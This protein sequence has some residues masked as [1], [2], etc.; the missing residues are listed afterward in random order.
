AYSSSKGALSILT[1]CLAEELKGYSVK[2]N[3]LALGAVQTEMFSNAF[4][5][6]KAPLT[7][8]EMAQFI[9]WFAVNGHLFFNGKILPVATS[10]P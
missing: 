1:E 9:G 4:P 6:M 2:C 8:A 10:T 3:A 5:E 7:A